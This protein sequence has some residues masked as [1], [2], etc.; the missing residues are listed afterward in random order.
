MGNKVSS[1]AGKHNLW[2]RD[3]TPDRSTAHHG[4]AG[5]VGGGGIC[6]ADTEVSKQSD[7][8][9]NETMVGLC[10]V[11]AGHTSVIRCMQIS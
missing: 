1:A 2:K 11:V 4:R 8:G 3:V 9:R 6:A 5:T 10:K 7:V